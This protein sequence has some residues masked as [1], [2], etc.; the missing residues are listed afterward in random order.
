[1]EFKLKFERQ[2]GIRH[3]KSGMARAKPLRQERAYLLDSS[4][5]RKKAGVAGAEEE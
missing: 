1:M 4:Q 5:S 2:E 3:S